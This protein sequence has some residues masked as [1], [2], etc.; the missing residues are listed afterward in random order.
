MRSVS[1]YLPTLTKLHKA[2]TL[3]NTF[4]LF[5]VNG[6]VVNESTQVK[7]KSTTFVSVEVNLQISPHTSVG[8]QSLN[9]TWAWRHGVDDKVDNLGVIE[10]CWNSRCLSTNIPHKIEFKSVGYERN[11]QYGVFFVFSYHFF[12]LSIVYFF[13]I[14]ST[15]FQ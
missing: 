4:Q 5:W 6:L 3:L 8:Q 1:V 14:L 10:L 9:R 2:T 11:I 7:L 12:F 15:R 13:L